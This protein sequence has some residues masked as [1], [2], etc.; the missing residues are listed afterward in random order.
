MSLSVPRDRL[1]QGTT[2]I[3]PLESADLPALVE[4]RIRNREFLTSGSPRA[5]SRSSRPPGRR[6]SWRSTMRPGAP[7]RAS[8]SRSSTP[9]EGDRLI[10]RVAL[11]NV[12]RG[13]WQNATL[14]YWVSEDAG[15]RGHATRAVASRCGSRSRSR[16]CTACS[17]RSCPATSVPSRVVEKCGFR[18]E[19]VAAALPEDQRRLVDGLGLLNPALDPHVFPELRQWLHQYKVVA[20]TD[21]CVIYRKRPRH[22]NIAAHFFFIRVKATFLSSPSTMR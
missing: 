13:V 14:G 12:V 4:A 15:S 7:R 6:A 9:S 2:A 8:R 3:R 16:D 18:H 21:L 10:G 5:T 1:Q 20:R 22:S 17:R 11:A 19:G